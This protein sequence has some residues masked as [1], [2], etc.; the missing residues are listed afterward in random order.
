MAEEKKEEKKKKV[1][2]FALPVLVVFLVVG[3]FGAGVM[4][5]RTKGGEQE[6]EKPSE[7]ENVVEEKVVQTSPVQEQ[8]A[9]LGE[10]Q[11]AQLEEG[12]AGIKGEKGAPIT[13]VEF[14][15]YEC[16]FCQRYVEDAYVQIWQ[17]YADKI[18]Y[19]FHDYPLPFHKHAQKAAEAARCAGAQGKYWEMHDLLFKNRDT[20]VG[21]EDSTQDFNAYAQQLGLKKEEFAACLSSGKQARAVQTDF[22]LG[23]SVGVQGTPTFFI[24]GQKLVGAQP[25]EAF[26]EI[27]EAELGG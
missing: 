6:T 20:W 13:I 12:A 16:P 2:I 19:I 21:K 8:A 5:S 1:T 7:S 22:E 25:F 15:E 3:A 18:R 24:N 10:E 9:V 14:S 4:W 26:K 23:Q 17:K 11:V 27:I